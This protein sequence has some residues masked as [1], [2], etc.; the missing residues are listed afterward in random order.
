L[1]E[2]VEKDLDDIPVSQEKQHFLGQ[3]LSV[4]LR[5]NKVEKSFRVSFPISGWLTRSL[6]IWP[7]YPSDV[8]HAI[9]TP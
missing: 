2:V 5:K 7:M 6:S 3:P 8:R 1:D 9:L 4:E